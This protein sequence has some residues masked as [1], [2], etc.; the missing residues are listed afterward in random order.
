VDTVATPLVATGDHDVEWSKRMK[1]ALLFL[2]LAFGC[3]PTARA[4]QP[5]TASHSQLTASDYEDAEAH[6][7]GVELASMPDELQAAADR[8]CQ[9]LL[10]KRNTGRAIVYGLGGLTGAGGIATLIPKDATEAERKQWDLGLGI[11]TLGTATATTILGALVQ[12]WTDEYE[13]KCL[14]ETPPAAEIE[15]AHGADGGVE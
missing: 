6:F 8:E 10:N 12:S 5:I 14:T 1:T 4:V 3:S 9:E 15:P 13:T 11:A 2:V 7:A